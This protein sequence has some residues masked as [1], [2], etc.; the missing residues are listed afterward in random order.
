MPL[1]YSVL[2]SDSRRQQRVSCYYLYKYLLSLFLRT[3]ETTT[4][5]RGAAPFLFR[6]LFLLQEAE[7]ED[8]QCMAKT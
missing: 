6:K 8:H 1:F 2:I 7:K 5:V 3:T 4:K